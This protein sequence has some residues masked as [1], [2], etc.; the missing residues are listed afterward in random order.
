MLF[1]YLSHW[2]EFWK[3]LFSTYYE[4]IYLSYV[5]VL[6][7]S[8]DVSP[9]NRNIV[10]DAENKLSNVQVPYSVFVWWMLRMM[11]VI[12]MRIMKKV[13]MYHSRTLF[14]FLL[15]STCGKNKSTPWFPNCIANHVTFICNHRGLMQRVT[16]CTYRKDKVPV[17]IYTMTAIPYVCKDTTYNKPAKVQRFG[18]VVKM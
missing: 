1:L 13:Q 14:S 16:H 7:S 8:I 15:P 11:L 12:R 18:Q 3:T 10:Y 5:T 17:K 2:N 6:L 9:T 4:N